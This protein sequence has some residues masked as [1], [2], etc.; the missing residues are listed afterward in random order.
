MAGQST[1]KF[2]HDGEYKYIPYQQLFK[3]VTPVVVPGYGEYEGYAN[4][5]SLKYLETYGLHDVKTMLRGTLRNKGFCSAWD[6]LVQLGCCDDTFE[7]DNVGSMTHAGFIQSFVESDVVCSDDDMKRLLWSGLFSDEK[8]GLTKG[9]PAQIL[10][11][12]LNKKWKLQPE[13]KD[14]VVMWH[15]FRYKQGA[16]SKT[17]EASLV[18]KGSNSVDTAMAKTV[19]LPLGIAAK[20]LIEGKIKQRGVVIPTTQ[21]IYEPVLDEL[22]TLGVEL[23]EK[24]TQ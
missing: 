13:D 19:G 9:T 1:A 23:T 11:H 8:V 5:D 24:I 16:A 7:M 21:D 20:L 6:V 18:A 3:R 12:I 22:K 10:E 2:L 17:L 14:L 15:R 4:R